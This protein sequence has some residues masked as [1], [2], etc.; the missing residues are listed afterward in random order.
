MRARLCIRLRSTLQRFS[1]GTDIRYL[2]FETEA[3]FHAD[4]VALERRGSR[5]NLLCTHQSSIEY[6]ARAT[7]NTTR[8]NM[9]AAS[10][11]IAGSLIHEPSAAA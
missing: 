10:T 2:R 5:M 3:T 8:I 4:F 7:R 1:H 9:H 11:L 6:P